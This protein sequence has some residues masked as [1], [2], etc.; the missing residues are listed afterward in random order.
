MDLPKLACG[1]RRMLDFAIE[2]HRKAHQGQM[3][4]RIDLHPETVY[5]WRCEMA[6]CDW[7]DLCPAPPV[8][9]KY[10]NVPIL[11]SER[12]RAPTMITCRNAIEEL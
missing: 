9:M 6:P 5:A 11:V 7:M 2:Q 8:Q 1:V 12:V 10:R 3:P 4:R